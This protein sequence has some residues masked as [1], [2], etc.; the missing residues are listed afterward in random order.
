MMKL[1]HFDKRSFFIPICIFAFLLLHKFKAILTEHYF[2]G[3]HKSDK[4][5]GKG[6]KQTCLCNMQQFYMGRRPIYV[7]Y[8]FT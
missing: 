5:F 1:M 4:R 8:P 3:V 2:T 7:K 6:I